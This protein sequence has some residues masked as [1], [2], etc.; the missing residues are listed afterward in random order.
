MC[1]LG[2]EGGTTFHGFAHASWTK[3]STATLLTS[4]LPS[5]HNA[6]SKPSALSPDVEMISEVLKESGYTTGGIVSNINLAESFG[7]D[8]GY[9]EYHYLGPDYLAFAEESSS[10]LIIYNIVRAVWFKLNKGLRFGDFYQ[11]SEVVNGVAFDW[12]NRHHDDRFFLFLHYMDVHDPYFEHPYNGNAIARVSNQHPDE[13]LA[14]E[15]HRLYN[16][17]IEYLDGNIG[18]LFA[19]MKRLGIYDDTV[20]AL[21]A[22]HGEEFFDH[23]GWWHGLTLYDEQIHVPFL[24]KWQKGQPA[25]PKSSV[26]E[27]ARII[28]VAPTLIART[29]AEV[30]TSMQGLDLMLD[31]KGRAAKD[32]EVFSE[33][34]HEGNVLWSLRT[35]SMK[36][37]EANPGNPRGL[38]ETELYNV[39]F[40]SGET[41]NLAGGNYGDEETRLAEQ[42][43]LQLRAAKGH[44]IH[45]GGEAKMSREECEQ[46]MNLGYIEDCSH[47][48]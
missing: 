8:Q 46:L 30:P 47:I 29:G 15:M 24:V 48:Q 16:G 43:G 18:K 28:D 33:E 22:D 40:D 35:K 2:E 25:P 3:P 19:E 45:G 11:D 5:S 37:I 1:S 9:D 27:L 6:M 41:K 17:E 31:A 38:A 10:K 36:L 21:V 20:I 42:A 26:D 13:S 12:L 44:A 23:G 39:Q 14:E 4:L 34:D 32:L 7:F